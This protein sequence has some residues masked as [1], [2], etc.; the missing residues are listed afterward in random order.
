MISIHFATFVDINSMWEFHDKFSFNTSPKKLKSLTRSIFVPDIVSLGEKSSEVFLHLLKNMF[1]VFF[2]RR[3]YD[4][5]KVLLYDFTIKIIAKLY[6]FA[7]VLTL[8]WDSLYVCMWAIIKAFAKDVGIL[9]I[10]DDS[11]AEKHQQTE[12]QKP[13]GFGAG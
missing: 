13:F 5:N 7:S 3:P 10:E 1:L 12:S 9:I 2:I 6:L 4:G 11:Q 8:F